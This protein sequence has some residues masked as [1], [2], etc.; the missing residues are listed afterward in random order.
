MVSSPRYQ[1]NLF[2]CPRCHAWVGNPYY[3]GDIHDNVRHLWADNPNYSVMSS[4]TPRADKPNYPVMSLSTHRPLHQHHML[5]SNTIIECTLAPQFLHISP[6]ELNTAS[7]QHTSHRRRFGLYT[8]QRA[9]S[10][11]RARVASSLSTQ[12]YIIHDIYTHTCFTC[13]FPTEVS[14]TSISASFAS[15]STLHHALALAFTFAL[16]QRVMTF[17]VSAE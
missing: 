17:G 1:G 15:T 13:L 4:S 6:A 7:Y 5:G 3:L 10:T 14:M 9:A 12:H 11:S 2:R 8:A 16:R